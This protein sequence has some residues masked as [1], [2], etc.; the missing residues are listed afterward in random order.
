MSTS[1]PRALSWK[2]RGLRDTHVSDCASGSR[3]WEEVAEEA[4]EGT[5]QVVLCCEEELER[6]VEGEIVLEERASGEA[7]DAKKGYEGAG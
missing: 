7:K 1:H 3:G 5:G 2:D 4:E 6:I